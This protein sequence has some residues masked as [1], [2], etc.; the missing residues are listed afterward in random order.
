MGTL[1]QLSIIKGPTR[2][3]QPGLLDNLFTQI[4]TGPQKNNT[5]IIY[6]G[7]SDLHSINSEILITVLSQKI[8]KPGIIPTSRLINSPIRLP[9]LFNKPLNKTS[10]LKI[11]MGI[12]LW[13]LICIQVTGEYFFLYNIFITVFLLNFSLVIVLLSIWK[14]GCAYLPLD[15]A[16]PGPR[17]EHIIRE[18]RPVL[19]IHDEGNV[20]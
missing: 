18:S 19:V 10:C 14:S 16:F 1:H 12:I 7:N 20:K 15:H 5:A 6:K 17:I 13:L 9:E 8:I 3:L 2:P 11:R 4:A